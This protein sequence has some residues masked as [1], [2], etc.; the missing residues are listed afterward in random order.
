MHRR[1]ERVLGNLRDFRSAAARS[2]GSRF[3]ATR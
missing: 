3:R 2:N 1:I